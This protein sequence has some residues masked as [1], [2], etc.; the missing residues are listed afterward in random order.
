VACRAAMVGQRC[1]RCVS[2]AATPWQCTWVALLLL[3]PH[4]TRARKGGDEM[5]GRAS[6]G[7]DSYI[8][9]WLRAAQLSAGRPAVLQRDEGEEGVERLSRRRQKLSPRY[10]ESEPPSDAHAG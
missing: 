9:V 5:T 10:Y 6:D 7:S 1:T 8:G 3:L 4:P 2:N